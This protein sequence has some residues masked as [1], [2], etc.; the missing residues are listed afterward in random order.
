M[1]FAKTDKIL[2]EGRK[3]STEVFSYRPDN[4]EKYELGQLYLVGEIS[5]SLNNQSTIF[6]L[7]SIASILK[8]TYYQYPEQGPEKRLNAALQAI[9]NNMERLTSQTEPEKLSRH[10][11]L[12][13][14]VV[15]PRRIFFSKTD[16]TSIFLLREKN[17]LNI[18]AGQKTA[19]NNTHK[20]FQNVVQG[21]LQKDDLVYITTS[22]VSPYMHQQTF[23]GHLTESRLDGAENQLTRLLN[24]T[25]PH[26]AAAL[27]R[28]H[29]QKHTGAKPDLQTLPLHSTAKRL[30]KKPEEDNQEFNKAEQANTEQQALFPG[31]RNTGQEKKEPSGDFKT[32]P[33]SS[34][35]NRVKTFL[36]NHKKQTTKI[37]QNAKNLFRS[38]NFTRTQW[39]LLAITALIVVFTVAGGV[40]LLGNARLSPFAQ[41]EHPT[42]LTKAS[43]AS[44]TNQRISFEGLDLNFSPFQLLITEEL[45]PTLLATDEAALYK[46]PLQQSSGRIIFFPENTAP[47]DVTSITPTNLTL[48]SS[49]PGGSIQTFNLQE[50]V[51]QPN[52]INIPTPI[53]AADTFRKTTYILTQEDFTIYTYP[54]Q[55]QNPD[56]EQWNQISLSSLF[57]KIY[58]MQIAKS[59]WIAGKDQQNKTIIIKMQEGKIQQKIVLANLTGSGSPAPERL[60]MYVSNQKNMLLVLD[61]ALDRIIQIDTT[62]NVLTK[63][64]TDNSLGDG[65]DIV[66]SSSAQAFFVLTKQEVLEVK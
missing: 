8:R 29:I 12:A 37:F 30:E 43:P 25:N 35:L 41:P 1:L 22:L 38:F 16:Y 11:H 33:L 50:E 15:N 51:F 18:G 24:S 26:G 36:Q 65:Q 3:N 55:S 23:R 61:P 31:A 57:Q 32:D 14:V 42:E 10:L 7:N 62:N 21:T 27:L 39:H 45:A 54:A 9:N 47:V 13:T 49:S 5:N 17:W 2:V 40:I 53:L 63:Q 48:F 28:L 4:I 44:S 58:D 52:S 6:L 20:V 19:P 66:Y 59:V 34:H 60:A 64:I 56:L 46:L